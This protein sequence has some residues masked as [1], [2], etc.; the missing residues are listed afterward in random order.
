MVAVL[1]IVAVDMV[2]PLVNVVL[3]ALVLV[4]V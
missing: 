4:V 1:L 2:V 3:D